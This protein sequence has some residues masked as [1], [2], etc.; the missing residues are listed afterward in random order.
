MSIRVFF[1]K[2]RY[3]SV[4]AC[5]IRDDFGKSLEDLLR[6]QSSDLSKKQSVF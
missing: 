4:L 3:V 1:L 2:K 6:K 5:I